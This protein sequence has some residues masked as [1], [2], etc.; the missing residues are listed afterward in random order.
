MKACW[1]HEK[2]GTNEYP[3]FSLLGRET[4]RY[5][6]HQRI[7]KPKDFKGRL[8]NTDTLRKDSLTTDVHISERSH[9]PAY[10]LPKPASTLTKIPE[11]I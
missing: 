9:L 10:G 1:V 3:E 2:V 7:F 5:I 8:V 6:G 4:R 11:V